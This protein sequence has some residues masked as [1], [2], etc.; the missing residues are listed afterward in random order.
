MSSGS[1]RNSGEFGKLCVVGVCV[2]RGVFVGVFDGIMVAVGMREGVA[3][4]VSVADGGLEATRVVTV[5]VR[6]RAMGVTVGESPA[7]PTNNTAPNNNRASRTK[8]RNRLE[9]G[10]ATPNPTSVV[11]QFSTGFLLLPPHNKLVVLV[12]HTTT[13]RQPRTLSRPLEVDC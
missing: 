11:N 13:V 9:Q 6:A 2:G 10:I 5:A 1:G 4:T 3:A 12:C 7:Q 8:G